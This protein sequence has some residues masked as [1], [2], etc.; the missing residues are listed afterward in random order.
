M[1]G[2]VKRFNWVSSATAWERLQAWQE[3]RRAMRE[4]FDTANSLV[5]DG[6]GAAWSNQIAGTS[7]LAAQA[8]QDR[9]AAAIQAKI[10]KIA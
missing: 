1:A 7:E 2:Q 3:R 10:N 8:A 4:T 5:R 6:F 9:V